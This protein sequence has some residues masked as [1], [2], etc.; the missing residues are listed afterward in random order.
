MITSKRNRL[1]VALLAAT[2]LGGCATG[3]NVPESI[4]MNNEDDLTE[5]TIQEWA[6]KVSAVTYVD[7]N[8]PLVIEEPL[9]LPAKIRNM[10]FATS[11]NLDATMA[12]LAAYLEPMGL[13][14][15]IP[16]KELAEKKMPVFNFKGRLGDFLNAIGV[17]YGVSFNWNPGDIVTVESTA[18]YM[19]RIPQD[20][21][22][23][24]T[25]A[26]NLEALGAE[27]VDTS[28][29]AGTISYRAGYRS[30]QRILNFLE[31]LSVNSA[32][33]SMQVAVINVAV[34]R[35]RK[36]GID[37]Q[38]LNMTLGKEA[39]LE[40]FARENQ[41]D[42]DV[43]PGFEHLGY[44]PREEDY[45][46]GRKDTKDNQDDGLANSAASDDDD[47]SSGSGSGDEDSFPLPGVNLSDLSAG[48]AIGGQ[49]SALKLAKGDFSFSAAIDYLSTYGETETRQS[50]ILKTL[51]GKNVKIKSG[52][53]VPY[54]ESIGVSSDSDSGEVSDDSMGK[55]DIQEVDIG[56]DLELLPY[57][58][59]DSELVTINVSLELSSLLSFIELSA[60]RQVGSVSRPNVQ[61]QEFTDVVKIKA[62]ESV[63]I[64]GITYDQGLDKTS[65]PS[66]ME[67]WGIAHENIE[68]KRNSMFIMMRPTVTVFGN[69]AKDKEIVRE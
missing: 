18:N 48:G 34:D 68:Y 47:S 3:R 41:E 66:F 17:A 42:Q 26:S 2:M 57:F 1:C 58:E 63:I 6:K 32:L 16:E 44:A 33:V 23:A 62:G 46:P 15:V 55:V 49:Q 30:H 52:Q 7:Q 28:V 37:W 39:T 35:S 21:T 12:S 14:V 13:Y 56:L 36:S 10:Q 59:A 27:D 22:L 29:E 65:A 24:E 53:K 9:R 38:D 43:V 50:L 60:G 67:R 61:Q 45:F 20:E 25:V 69:F 8:G 31:R 5:K 4:N 19:L 51:S 11:M 40:R 54:I 64:G